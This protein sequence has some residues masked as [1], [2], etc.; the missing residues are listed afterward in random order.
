MGGRCRE[1]ASIL[2]LG[3]EACPRSGF[4]QGPLVELSNRILR[5]PTGPFCKGE[6]RGRGCQVSSDGRRLETRPLQAGNELS[7]V[8]F[9]NLIDV[10]IFAKVGLEDLHVT[11]VA[12]SRPRLQEREMLAAKFVAQD[13][14][15]DLEVSLFLA[16]LLA[17]HGLGEEP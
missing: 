14:Q 8:D 4:W 17:L 12:D 3:D 2:G 7:Y 10:T 11:E 6:Y 13:P 5:E 15:P 9:V 1:Q 16:L